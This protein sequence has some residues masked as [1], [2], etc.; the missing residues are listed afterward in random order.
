MALLPHR[1]L[2]AALALACAPLSSCIWYSGQTWPEPMEVSGAELPPGDSLEHAPGPEEVSVLRHSDPVRVRPA[3]S[4][5]GYPLAFYRKRA[6]LSA[7]GSL[8]VAPGGRAEI[9]WPSGSSALLFGSAIAWIGSPSRGDPLV[10][11]QELSSARFDL[12]PGDRVELLGGG[13]LA[14]DSGPYMVDRH[15][16]EVL[17]VRNQSDGV[18]SIAFRDGDFD[19]DPGQTLRLPLLSAGGRPESADTGFEQVAGPGFSVLA[20]GALEL[21]TGPGGVVARALED[22]PGERRL[23]ALGVVVRLDA[24]SRAVF[25]NLG[26]LPVVAGESAAL[27]APENTSPQPAPAEPAEDPSENERP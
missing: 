25:R 24:R 23:Q 8:V 12:M 9:L 17:R 5:T 26:D 4:L 7:G 18:L 2:L 15:G 21:E 3:G 16:D 27:T 20:R 10:S 6:R 19:L 22:P 1:T 13:V 11:F 14:G